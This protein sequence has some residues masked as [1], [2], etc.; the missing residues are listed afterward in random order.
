MQREGECNIQLSPISKIGI[1]HAELGSA[2]FEDKRQI[3]KC[4]RTASIQRDKFGMTG[5]ILEMVSKLILLKT[6]HF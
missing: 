4:R 5:Y 2:L 6:L 3:P 1:H